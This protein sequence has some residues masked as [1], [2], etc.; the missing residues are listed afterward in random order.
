[1]FRLLAGLP[2]SK[3]IVREAMARG[4]RV[5][6]PEEAIQFL[7]PLGYLLTFCSS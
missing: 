4:V 3:H 1:V 5:T 6:V 7:C 2:R